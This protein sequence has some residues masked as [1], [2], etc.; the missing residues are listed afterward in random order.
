MQ[1]ALNY[2]TNIQV[3]N[4]NNNKPVFVHI[5]FAHMEISS[6]DVHIKGRTVLVF[7]FS[8]SWWQS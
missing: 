1:K 2:I 6:S 5:L 7:L 4:Y 8:L 3:Y